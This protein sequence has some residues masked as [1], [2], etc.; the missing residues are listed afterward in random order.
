MMRLLLTNDDGVASPGLAAL[1]GALM[2]AGHDTM[3]VAPQQDRH[4]AQVGGEAA[5]RGH[6]QH[7]RPG[8]AGQDRQRAPHASPERH[9]V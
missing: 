6:R 2:R 3:V 5:E 4:L 1:A 7:V 9:P 8:A